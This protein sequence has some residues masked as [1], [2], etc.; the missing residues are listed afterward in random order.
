MPLEVLIQNN[1]NQVSD[2]GAWLKPG[3]RLQACGVDLNQGSDEEV[4]IVPN[5]DVNFDHALPP[6]EDVPSSGQQAA[7]PSTGGG[8]GGWMG[9]RSSWMAAGSGGSGQDASSN[10]VGSVDENDYSDITGLTNGQRRLQSAT[11]PL[12]Q[13]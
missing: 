6:V 10:T 8:T 3:Q 5:P 9:S 4:A 7:L 12:L 2:L 11:R 13:T 1:L